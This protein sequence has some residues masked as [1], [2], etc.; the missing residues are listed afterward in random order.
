LG[1]NFKKVSF[2]EEYLGPYLLESVTK[3]LYV[4]PLHAIREYVQN[5]I[6]SNPPA[7]E[8][9]VVLQGK[10]LSI[11]DNGGGMNEKDLKIAVMLGRSTKNP[12]DYFGFRGLGIYS[13]IPVCNKIVLS[14]KRKGEN[15]RLFLEI[16]AK[17]LSDEIEA[18]TQKSLLKLLTDH[19]SK[20]EMPNA[21][22]RDQ[23]THVQLV[24]ILDDY[25]HY[26]TPESIEYY[27]SQVLP[28]EIDPRFP[29]RDGISRE[30]SKE[31]SDYRVSNIYFNG[32]PIYRPPY[33]TDVE[34]PAFNIL[35]DGKGAPLAFYWYCMH[36]D[37][38]QIEEAGSSG[39]VYKKKGFTVGDPSTC[40]SSWFKSSQHLF[41]WAVGEVHVI[42]DL[43]PNSERMDFE[44]EPLKRTLLNE[45]ENRLKVA[46]EEEGRKRSFLSH[47]EE[48]VETIKQ[49]S[50]KTTFK[51]VEEKTE[52][53]KEISAIKN[54]LL[55]DKK[56]EFIK[57]APHSIKSKIPSLINKAKKLQKAY[58]SAPI[59]RKG[60][61]IPKPVRATEKI[62]LKRQP[63]IPSLTDALQD[64]DLTEQAKEIIEI[65]EKT[66]DEYF[67]KTP[68][69]CFEIKQK[70]LDRLL[71]DLE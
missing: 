48:N 18:E 54:A 31:V 24:D 6:E 5:G 63:P 43:K 44:D 25:K 47:L 37:D 29:Y 10:T 53:I 22:V 16:D 59:S 39:I 67:A 71:K 50:S 20:A 11:L 60:A 42:A 23:G 58:S 66:I 62:L 32:K 14:T 51:S 17:G 2:T 27:M 26:F 15:K 65:V 49:A 46:V 56:K 13:G 45:L 40:I 21:P 52:T 57:F 68:T 3:G 12:R 9:K 1:L 35:R 28:V 38:K 36:K 64:I 61:P 4:D 34:R 70:I 41:Y 33:I 7:S 19:I 55:R 69:A 30:L 8:V